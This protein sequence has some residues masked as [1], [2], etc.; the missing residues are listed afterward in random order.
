MLVDIR[1][2]IGLLSRPG[3]MYSTQVFHKTFPPAIAKEMLQS[4]KKTSCNNMIDV[5]RI[6]WFHTYKQII[7]HAEM[8]LLMQKFNV[9]SGEYGQLK[10]KLASQG[11]HVLQIRNGVFK[12]ALRDCFPPDHPALKMAE[13]LVGPIVLAFPQKGKTVRLQALA[14]TVATKKSQLMVIGGKIDS[15]VLT[16]QSFDHVS[17]LPPLQTLRAELVA[18]LQSPASQL[19]ATL[20]RP[21][22]SIASILHQHSLSK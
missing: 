9:T 7:Q 14:D 16:S 20:S 10:L 12:A 17:R 21:S 11:F 13:L 1:H 22:Q 19:A 6:Y 3:L 8:V 5:R 18:L 2:T 4:A 15:L